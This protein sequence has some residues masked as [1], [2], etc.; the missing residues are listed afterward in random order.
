MI[1]VLETDRLILREYRLEDFP[2]HAA[3][4]ADPRTTRDFHNAAEAF[5]E[6]LCWLR[7]L[8]SF[9]QWQLF[10]YGWWGLEEK[11]SGRYIGS[12]GF[13]HAKRAIEIPCRDAPEAGW[14]LVPDLHGRGLATEAVRAALAWADANIA[15]PESWCMI[16]PKNTPSQKI[17]ERFGYRR[18]G[19]AHYKGDEVLTYLRP[20]WGQH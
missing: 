17:A 2:F 9:G 16:G 19:D 20:R 14:V 5:D 6:E 10:G 4:W 7:F 15:A 1:P 18:S 3:M 13:F 8:R 11:T 12:V